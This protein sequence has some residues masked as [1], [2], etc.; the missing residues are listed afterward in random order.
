MNDFLTIENFS[1]YNHMRNEQLNLKMHE[2]LFISILKHID[3]DAWSE[4]FNIF[5]Y[6]TLLW[7]GITS[8]V[9]S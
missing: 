6:H 7:V 3:Q 9:M 2:F 5:A 1:L 4:S 8:L